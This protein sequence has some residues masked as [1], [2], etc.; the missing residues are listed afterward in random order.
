LDVAAAIAAVSFYNIDS[1]VIQK[2][3]AS[4]LVLGADLSWLV[5]LTAR[6]LFPIMPIIQLN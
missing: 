1:A 3:V 2:A 5:N 6:P 4:F